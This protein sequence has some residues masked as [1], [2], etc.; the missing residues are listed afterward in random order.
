[1]TTNCMIR[2]DNYKSKS[3]KP[4][5]LLFPSL[6]PTVY[7]HKIIKEHTH[8]YIHSARESLTPYMHSQVCSWLIW[9]R[10][11]CFPP[12]L[13]ILKAFTA[14]SRAGRVIA[15]LSG[16]AAP[17]IKHSLERKSDRERIAREWERGRKEARPGIRKCRLSPLKLLSPRLRGKK[18]RWRVSIWWD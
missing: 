11:V 3:S 1:M 13:I 8:T 14:C 6:V 4:V 9:R 7:M 2:G 17:Q 18:G 16:A 12:F 15:P 10:R 5:W